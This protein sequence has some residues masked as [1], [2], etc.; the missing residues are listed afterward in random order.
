MDALVCKEVTEELRAQW[1]SLWRNRIDDKVRAEG[2]ADS[3]YSMLFVEKGT[4]IFATRKFRMLNLR[5]I[6]EKHKVVDVNRL[7]Q[8]SSSVGGWGKFIRTVVVGER[9]VRRVRRVAPEVD[10]VKGRQ[11]LKKGGRGWLHC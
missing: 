3:D 11:Q 6:A 7:V 2:I 5:E 4:V 9:P 8:P 10:V 1:K